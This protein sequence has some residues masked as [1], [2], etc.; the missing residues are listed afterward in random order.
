MLPECQTFWTAQRKLMGKRRGTLT[1][2]AA[3]LDNGPLGNPAL[4]EWKMHKGFRGF[5]GRRLERTKIWFVC[6]AILGMSLALLAITFLTLDGYRTVFG[7]DLGAD[8]AGFYTA[9]TLLNEYPS[10]RLYDLE[11]QDQLYHRLL[12]HLAPEVTLPYVHPPF[13]A[14]L[15]RPLAW[16]PY[17]WAYIVWLL[18]S[19]GLVLTSLLLMRPMLD[20][21][22][23]P[24]L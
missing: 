1:A 19:V 16:L 12:P 5:L 24:R 20:A 10:E 18:F 15:F 11:L 6:L 8:F 3:S 21:I 22:P 14:V 4:E 23:G 9:G 13:F 17:A 7:P 2:A